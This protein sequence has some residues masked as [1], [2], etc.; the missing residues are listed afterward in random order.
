M[1]ASTHVG[2]HPGLEEPDRFHD[3]HTSII[4]DIRYAL[5]P[6]L[7]IT[8]EI[9]VEKT[10]SLF[11]DFGERKDYVP[12]ARIDV[13]ETSLSSAATVTTTEFEPNFL[14]E[15]PAKPQRFLAIY[16]GE[17][18]LVTTIEILSPA[19]KKGIGFEEFS[20]KQRHLASQGINLVEIDLLRKGSRRW[21]GNRASNVDYL[22]TVQREAASSVEAWS[23]SVGEELP[24]IPVPLRYGDGQ[25]PLSLEEVVTAYLQKSGLG[26]RLGKKN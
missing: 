4:V 3:F 22:F 11:D 14:L 16:D 8:Y 20:R 12:D 25:V 9:S 13:V 17:G 26:R 5:A 15:S 24:K 7:P 6:A 23:A 19:N 21:T 1:D 18:T 10:L 2:M